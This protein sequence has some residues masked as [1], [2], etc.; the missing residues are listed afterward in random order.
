MEIQRFLIV[1]LLPTVALGALGDMELT[2]DGAKLVWNN[3]SQTFTIAASGSMSASI[4]YTWPVTDAVSGGQALLSD[5]SGLLS[6]GTPTTSAAHNFLSGTH[7]DTVANTVTRGSI[8]YGNSTPAW[9]ELTIGA[10]NTFLK[11]DGTDV[12]WSTL[13]VSAP[14][15]LSGATISWDSTLIDATTWSDGSNASNI[16]I[17]DISG[18]DH[19]MTASSALM[20]FSHSLTVADVITGKS[21]TTTDFIV[22]VDGDT[23]WVGAGAG[24]AYGLMYVDI[25]QTI[26][27]ALTDDTPTE[28]EDDGTTSAE[29]GWL[30]G[31]LNLVTFPSGGTEHY[32]AVIK[33]GVY[34]ADW[35]LS[36]N[37]ANPGANVEIHGGVAVNDTPQRNNGEAHRTIAN[38]SDT[39]NMG[40]T[41]TI[42]CTNGNEEISLWLENTTNDADV[43][44]VHG[45]LSIMLV[46][47]ITPITDV[48]LLETGDALL[49]ETGD[50]MLLE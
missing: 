4:D 37:M 47:G 39:G 29:D 44:V 1:L 46:G 20:T 41:A 14:V 6:W 21:I 10:V 23:Y 19:T 27:V 36:F 42:N 13:S 9:D 26:I 30:G 40:A 32:L 8:I 16:W 43:T 33:A 25:T 28:V 5:A 48:L 45:N 15:T 35:D 7:S 38:N 31:G 34:K 22:E 12:A 49:L 2:V 11:S 50:R 3:N 18:I 17:F 24:L